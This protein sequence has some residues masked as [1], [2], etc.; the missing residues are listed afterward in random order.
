MNIRNG[1]QSWA[2]IAYTYDGKYVM[3]PYGNVK[4]TVDGKYIREGMGSYGPIKYTISG[5]CIYEGSYI[6]YSIH[7]NKVIKDTCQ[8]WG[9]VAYTLD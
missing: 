8:S 9:T 2:T 7:G 6:A 4:Y 3:D 1:A 5:N